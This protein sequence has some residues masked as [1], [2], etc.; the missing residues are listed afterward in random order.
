[1]SQSETAG[2]I[3]DVSPGLTDLPPAQAGKSRQ[4]LPSPVLRLTSAAAQN[5]SGL[6]SPE[7]LAMNRAKWRSASPRGSFSF[8]NLKMIS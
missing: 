5:T 3:N 1:M 8:Y 6:A 4:T 7:I 2:V